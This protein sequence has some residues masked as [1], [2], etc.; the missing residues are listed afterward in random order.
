MSYTVDNEL[1][2]VDPLDYIKQ[3][4]ISGEVP[5]ALVLN[6]NLL[7]AAAGGA[8]YRDSGDLLSISTPGSSA[9]G[10]LARVQLAAYPYLRCSVLIE[11]SGG[12]GGTIQAK[13]GED[14][15][16][17]IAQSS[18]V[19]VSS[20]LRVY[21]LDITIDP[22]HVRP[23]VFWIDGYLEYGDTSL[24]LLSAELAPYPVDDVAEGALEVS[25]GDPLALLD[26]SL[27]GS[28]TRAL[29][30]D[31]VDRLLRG[32]YQVAEDRPG[33][34]YHCLPA[35]LI[36]VPSGPAW[37]LYRGT[38]LTSGKICRLWARAYRSP[39]S[40]G[41]LTITLRILDQEDSVEFRG[42]T[43]PSAPYDGWASC[44]ITELPAG[45]WDCEIV[46]KSEGTV[47]SITALSLLEAL[48]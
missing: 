2:V 9:N 44:E 16:T 18:A 34:L 17:L 6:H 27:H 26:E 31:T 20:G 39:A 41:I 1:Q 42:S 23:A 24:E 36:S 4:A 43:V 5:A 29:T 10:C 3:N 46:C 35:E 25:S 15:G 32:P 11:Y 30:V 45:L 14:D 37:T 47:G 38:V 19:A 21:E 13:L 48:E 8:L 40:A 28:N 12:S 22:D 33:H 7:A